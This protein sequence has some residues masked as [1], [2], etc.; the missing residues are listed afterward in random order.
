MNGSKQIGLIPDI[1]SILG[2]YGLLDVLTEYK[3]D[4]VF[5]SRLTWNKRIRK[6]M[7]EREEYWW[8]SRRLQPEFSRFK[9]IN[10][11]YTIHF[12]WTLSKITRS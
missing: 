10:S 7:Q 1:V 11:N 8:H 12:A 3:R 2:K 6:T 4:G 9:R 5:P